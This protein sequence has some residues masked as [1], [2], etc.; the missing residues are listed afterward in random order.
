[1]GVDGAGAQALGGSVRQARYHCATIAGDGG[2]IKSAAPVTQ[3]GA[4]SVKDNAIYSAATTAS[5]I[6]AVLTLVVPSL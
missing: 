5:P 6:W 2:A 4:F 1:M 3:S